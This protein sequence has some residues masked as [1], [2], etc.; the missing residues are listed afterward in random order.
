MKTKYLIIAV[1]VLIQSIG[2]SQK[3]S[4]FMVLPHDKWMTTHGF[5]KTIDNQG[6]ET[7]IYN[8]KKAVTENPE[9]L[10]VISKVEGLLTSRG[11][12]TESM[13][14]KLQEINNDNAENAVLTSKTSKA[15]VSESAYDKFSKSIKA[16]FF[17][18]IDW[19]ITKTG[20]KN[21]IHYVMTAHDA[22]TNDQIA[23]AEDDGMPSF[24]ASTSVLLKEIINN[25]MDKLLGDIEVYRDDIIENGRPIKI[26]I[27]KW[28][29]WNGDL[30]KEY[31]GEELRDIIEDWMSKNSVKGEIGKGI[32]TEN[33][34]VFQPRMPLLD[35]NGKDM[36]AKSFIKPLSKL[37]KLPPYSIENKLM[38][39]GL[40]KAQLML[41]EK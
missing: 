7:P 37:L 18:K 40:G 1:V 14:E 29:S 9:L 31:N 15:S 32:S 23:D 3:K 39:K 28:D 27:K 17:L 34:I 25:K 8:Y 41:G 33:I 26:V 12:Q 13:Y 36:D 24:E 30:E 4:V 6:E 21:Q 16:D 35:E 19:Y 38:D 10:G 22:Y 20:P 11:L 2:F 5:V